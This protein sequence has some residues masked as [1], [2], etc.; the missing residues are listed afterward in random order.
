MT[1]HAGTTNP[2]A[3]FTLLELLVVVGIVGVIAAIAVGV[4]SEQ[5]EKAMVT[6]VAADLRT[7]ETGFVSYASDM[8]DFPP[9]SHL[10]GAYHLPAGA[11]VES[12][13]P[14]QRWA[15]ETPLG[16]NYNWEGPDHYPY[17]GVS[18]FQPSAPASTFA[19]LDKTLDDGD[20]SQGKFRLGNNGRYT[21]I[22]NE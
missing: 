13:L 18:L 16:G 20:L 6:A 22:I 10:D 8:G 1:E 12:Y 3:G 7:F 4:L 14:V 15:A 21:Y 11:G 2:A 5:T 9:D 19:L 17:A